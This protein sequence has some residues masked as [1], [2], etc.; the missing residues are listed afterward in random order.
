MIFR[1]KGNEFTIVP[2]ISV[3]VL[4]SDDATFFEAVQLLKYTVLDMVILIELNI[5]AMLHL[6]TDNNDINNWIDIQNLYHFNKI[7]TTSLKILLE[8]TLH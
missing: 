7:C 4:C 8:K 1:K 3:W 2:K 5:L 6:K